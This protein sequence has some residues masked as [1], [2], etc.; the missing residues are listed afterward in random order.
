MLKQQST[1]LTDRNP[2]ESPKCIVE[3]IVVLALGIASLIS[4][5]IKFAVNAGEKM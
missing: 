5:I 4:P 3:S 2:P 1:I